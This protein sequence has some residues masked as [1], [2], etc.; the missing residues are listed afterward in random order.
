M[1]SVLW[2]DKVTQ[3]KADWHLTGD[4]ELTHFM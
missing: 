3:P 2:L 4:D 1:L